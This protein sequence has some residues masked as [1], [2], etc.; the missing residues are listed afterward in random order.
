MTSFIIR[1][2]AMTMMSSK[3]MC[4]SKISIIR[5]R[6][7][8]TMTILIIRMKTTMMMMTILMIM[9]RMRMMLAM[10]MRLKKMRV[11]IGMSWTERRLL[12]IEE[13]ISEIMRMREEAEINEETNS[14]DQAIKCQIVITKGEDIENNITCNIVVFFFLYILNYICSIIIFK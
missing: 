1:M 5:R 9:R 6:M 12:R 2:W 14:I 11:S 13:Q 8:M 3:I 7:K 4:L 10:M